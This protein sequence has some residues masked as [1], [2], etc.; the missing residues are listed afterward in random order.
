MIKTFVELVI[1]EIVRG[2]APVYHGSPVPLKVTSTLRARPRHS[3]F[4][5]RVSVDG[6][7]V[8]EFV[9]SYR[10][11][12]AVSRLKCIYGVNSVGDLNVAGASEDYVYEIVPI[13]NVT[14]AHF[15][16]VSKILRLVFNKQELLNN[17]KAIKFAK[18]YWSGVDCPASKDYAPAVREVL[19]SAV[20]IKKQVNE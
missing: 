2:S 10:P 8:E 13:G 11:S 17:P 1:E 4:D 12:T 16:W 20:K 18:A 14:R 3:E 5:D 6:V 15:G 19:C 9:E 7:S